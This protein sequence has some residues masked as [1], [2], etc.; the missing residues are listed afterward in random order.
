MTLIRIVVRGPT[1][2]EIEIQEQSDA[3]PRSESRA[4]KSDAPDI[5]Q[6]LKKLLSDIKE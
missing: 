2:H 4:K 1:I 6:T 3:D 5:E